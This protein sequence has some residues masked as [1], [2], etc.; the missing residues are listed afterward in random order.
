MDKDDSNTSPTTTIS[1]E[2]NAT[3]SASREY[4]RIAKAADILHCTT[5]DLLHLGVIGKIEILAPVMTHET[6]IWSAENYSILI[7]GLDEPLHREF[8]PADR[9]ILSLFDLAQIEGVGYTTPHHFYAPGKALELI[10]YGEHWNEPHEE[11]IVDSVT[12]NAESLGISSQVTVY[13]LT[14]KREESTSKLG[15]RHDIILSAVSSTP[16]IAQPDRHIKPKETTIDHLFVSK[17][18]TRRI[19]SN[20]PQDKSATDRNAYEAQ[21]ITKKTHGGGERHA[22]NREPM[23][24]AA[25]YCLGNFKH[26]L[27][28]ERNGSQSVSAAALTKLIEDRGRVFWGKSRNGEVFNSDVMTRRLSKILKGQIPD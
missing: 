7:D 16:W 8:G 12:T 15:T 11:E 25:I 3:L 19:L 20:A 21:T 9:V 24:N 28:R 13:K 6:Y 10:E 17:K 23:L 26:Q 4:Y 14:P 5:D 1:L 22:L 27:L 18:E 2:Y